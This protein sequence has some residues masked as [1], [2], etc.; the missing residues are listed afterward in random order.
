MIQL[1]SLWYRSQEL[2]QQF[3]RF[4]SFVTRNCKDS[5]CKYVVTNGYYS[6]TSKVGVMVI[7]LDDCPTVF[8]PPDQPGVPCAVSKTHNS[9][10]LSWGKPKYGSDSVQSYKVSYRSVDDPPDQW[11]TQTSS[12][13]Y[14]VLT[15]LTPGSLYCFKVT[16]ESAV[17]SSRV[18]GAEFMLPPDQ[19][20]RP[21]TTEVT[22]NSIQ[23]RWNKPER[24]TDSVQY[25]TVWYHSVDIQSDQW[26]SQSTTYA[27][28]F[29]LLTGLV[30]NRFYYVKIQ[31]VSSVGSSP[32]SEL[33]D[34][35]ETLLSP[36][37]KPHATNVTHNSVQLCWEKPKHGAECVQMYT[38]SYCYSTSPLPVVD[39]VNQWLILKFSDRNCNVSISELHANKAYV[40]K[41]RAETNAGPSPDSEL[42][43]PIIETL[44]PPPG[45]PCATNVN[46]HEFQVN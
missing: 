36:P 9:L 4:V 25:Y 29:A 18:V 23:L 3:Q 32:Y 8:E 37:G 17:G 12:E 38:V 16:A 1:Q 19:P 35:I 6:E 33:S 44:L 46:H 20:G 26:S 22:P 43:D 34:S 21:C 7:Y 13:E 27:Q 28:E 45:K 41:V 39:S 40:F 2:R 10:Q 31:A 42:S 11:S 15:K 24:G 14:A 30:P 5:A